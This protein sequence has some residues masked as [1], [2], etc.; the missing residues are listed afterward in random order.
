MRHPRLVIYERDG[1]L[2]E[3]VRELARE[4]RWVVRESRQADAC[5]KILRDPGPAVLLIKVDKEALDG[6]ALI[7]RAFESA[8]HCP[9][10]LFFD[11]KQEG[12]GQ[13]ALLAGLAYDLGASAVVFPPLTQSAVEDL[14]AG[15]M[16]GAVARDA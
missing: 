13:R 2:A 12:A 6:M 8:P 16:A 15:L 14:A 7:G 1:F 4:H 11:E 9:L 5:L 3:Q 10:A